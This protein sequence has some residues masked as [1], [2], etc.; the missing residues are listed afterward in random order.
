M[1]VTRN[2]NDDEDMAAATQPAEVAVEELGL[3]LPCGLD[4]DDDD[5][6]VPPASQLPSDGM[7]T[8]ATEV[9]RT[10]RP[11][12]TLKSALKV[13]NH[14][15]RNHVRFA[16]TVHAT[17]VESFK[18]ADLWW[19]PDQLSRPPGRPKKHARKIETRSAAERHA[20]S[21]S[22]IVPPL[23]PAAA[24]SQSPS[25]TQAV[26]PPAM[27]VDQ[28]DEVTQI[29]VGRPP[30]RP[31]NH[32]VEATK[33]D[34]GRPPG[35]MALS[36][37]GGTSRKRVGTPPPATQAAP[38]QTQHTSPQPTPA[39]VRLEALRERVRAKVRKLNED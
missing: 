26:S 23:V 31:N 4:D 14:R 11:R 39:Q 2:G 3:D 19:R 12:P 8:D 28:S 15:R 35:A 17:T 25:V 21:T 38:E 27:G 30:G 1:L 13:G 37:L 24:D 36:G 7:I 32:D 22:V 33:V 20:T 29:N 10:A 16:G 6:A 18:S 9:M 34:V 5:I